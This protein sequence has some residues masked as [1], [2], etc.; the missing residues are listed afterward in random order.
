MGSIGSHSGGS[1]ASHKAALM[2]VYLPLQLGAG[3]CW[4]TKPRF[5]EPTLCYHGERPLLDCGG[6]THS[7]AKG[8]G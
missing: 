2:A 7:C 6:P 4:D 8:D 3:A 1:S 5:C